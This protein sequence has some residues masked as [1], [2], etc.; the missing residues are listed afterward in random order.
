MTGFTQIVDGVTVLEGIARMRRGVDASVEVRWQELAPFV[1]DRGKVVIVP[2]ARSTGGP[3]ADDRLVETKR[4]LQ[5]AF[6]HAYGGDGYH[7]ETVLDPE[8]GYGRRLARAG[9]PHVEQLNA[10]SV[11]DVG[12]VL[13]HTAGDR[14]TAS[15]L[16][17]HIVPRAW[18]WSRFPHPDEDRERSRRHRLTRQQDAVDLTWHWPEE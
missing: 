6:I 7:A 4:R 15:N 12:A 2:L 5:Q 1:V 10:W 3:E 17:L 11:A 16:A 18:I 13:V 9:I 8:E 14:D